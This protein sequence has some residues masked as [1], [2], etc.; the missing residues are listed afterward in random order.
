M[1]QVRREESR[2]R[3]A[4]LLILAAVAVT[5][6][7]IFTRPVMIP[8]VLAILLSY[9]VAPV[10]DTLQSRL[11]APRWL[12]VV[13]AFC[14]VAALMTLLGLLLTTS[15]KG[16]LSKMPI[17]K[18]RLTELAASGLS[19]LDRLGLDLGQESVVAAVKELPLMEVVG[20]AAG[21]V[22]D[23]VSNL[24]LVLIFVIYLIIG[25][26]PGE[27]RTGLYGEIDAKVR[28]YIATKVSTSAV[29][30]V[31][32]G[33]I[34]WLFGLELAMV[35]GVLAFLLNFIPSVGSIIATLLPLPIALIQFESGLMVAACVALPGVVQ[36]T[37]GNV[38]EPKLMGEGLDLH[39]VTVLLALIF[40]GLVWGVPGMLLATP[41]TAVLRIVLDRIETT[42]PIGNL[43]AG[44][45]PGQ[46]PAE[47]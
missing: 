47:T 27:Q 23:L 13:L 37:I 3:T 17:Y 9:L 34:L 42:R 31:L 15:T 46:T 8:F 41:I 12:S 25:R 21:T 11:R 16:L 45:L 32:V 26:A 39:P 29:T 36:I 33:V 5:V 7:L 14:V 22:L 19:L 1:S 44:K 38:I 28:R 35:F 43:L 10:V 20:G 30:G 4:C 40:W 6:A 18:E 2:V 24:F